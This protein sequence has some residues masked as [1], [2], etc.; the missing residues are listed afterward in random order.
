MGLVPGLVMGL[1]LGLVLGVSAGVSAG[2]KCVPG[3][4]Q[5][6]GAITNCPSLLGADGSTR[7]PPERKTLAP[8][9]S[10]EVPA[11]MVKVSAGATVENYWCRRRREHEARSRSA[12]GARVG[13]GFDAGVDAGW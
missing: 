6:I 1:V 9:E 5:N 12:V 3:Y 2:H 7:E 8:L 4:V 13:T 10:F 11:V